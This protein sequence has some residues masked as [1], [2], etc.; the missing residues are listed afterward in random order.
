MASARP[1]V[2]PAPGPFRLDVVRPHRG[3][4]RRSAVSDHVVEGVLQWHGPGKCGEQASPPSPARP[5]EDGLTAWV[6][7]SRRWPSCRDAEES[8][9]ESDLVIGHQLPRCTTRQKQDRWSCRRPL[10]PSRMTLVRRVSRLGLRPHAGR[11]SKPAWVRRG[12]ERVAARTSCPA[13]RTSSSDCRHDWRRKS[14]WR[15]LGEHLGID[16][17]YE[18]WPTTPP[19]RLL[20]GHLATPSCRSTCSIGGSSST[21][22]SSGRPPAVQDRH[23]SSKML[24]SRATWT[25]ATTRRISVCFATCLTSCGCMIYLDVPPEVSQAASSE[26]GDSSKDS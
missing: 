9:A 7:R 21:R 5:R 16:V 14:P 1:W 26:D 6:S 12:R 8:R 15:A 19:A 3:G 23:S 13:L 11:G 24:P 2:G 10:A 20:R 22:R 25:T 17:Y 4:A 18:R